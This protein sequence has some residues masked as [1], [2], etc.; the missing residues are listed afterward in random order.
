MDLTIHIW[1][2]G[3]PGFGGFTWFSLETKERLPNRAWGYPQTF[4]PPLL[5]HTAVDIQL[6]RL[7][8]SE[9]HGLFPTKKPCEPVGF[10]LV[11]PTTRVASKQKH[12]QGT[13]KGLTVIPYCGWTKSISH[14][15]RNHG[16]AM[17]VNTDKQGF[18]PWFQ[19][20][21]SGFR[22]AVFLRMTASTVGPAPKKVL[23]SLDICT[24]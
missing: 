23:H 7:P 8:H 3:H 15:L 19:S 21:A 2:L 16:M 20:S 22:P 1:T 6:L 13:L 24:R 4:W 10:V 11:A 14:H 18:Q 9:S 12:H 5:R 17:L